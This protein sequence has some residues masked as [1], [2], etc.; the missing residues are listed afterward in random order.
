MYLLYL[1]TCFLETVSN[2]V[3]HFGELSKKIYFNSLAD[4]TE[5]VC[6][7]MLYLKWNKHVPYKF[8]VGVVAR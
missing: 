2:S 6:V 5:K 1:L 4:L 7:S 8:Y 3:Q